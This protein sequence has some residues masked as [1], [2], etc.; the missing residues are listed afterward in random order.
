M[1]LILLAAAGLLASAAGAQAQIYTQHF[2]AGAAGFTGGVA[3]VTANGN[4]YLQLTNGASS[5]L[6]VSTAG[7]TGLTLSFNLYGIESLDGNGPDG[8][9]P[10]NFL[11]YLNGSA[12]AAYTI[13][14]ANYNTFSNTQSYNGDLTQPGVYAPFTGSI[15]RGTLGY[16]T[17]PF[18]DSTYLVSFT[19]PD[20]LT[21]SVTFVGATNESAS[22][23]DGSTGG[24]EAYGIDNVN[25]TGTPVGTS[26][27]PEPATWVM[28]ILGFG[29]LGGAMRR[30]PKVDAKMSY[31][32]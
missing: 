31:A 4:N 17:G 28:T 15:A 13:N 21:T 14:I 5:T 30:R 25:L 10:D 24:N 2:S 20:N 3:A 8:G 7:Y 1:K 32:A 11:I 6:S 12:T 27:V 16:G 18:G 22:H 26:A 19:L 29:I 9:G 23:A